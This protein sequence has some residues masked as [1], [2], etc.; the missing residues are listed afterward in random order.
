L[1]ID[2]QP[3]GTGGRKMAIMRLNFYAQ[4][5]G[6]YTNVFVHIPSFNQGF[7]LEK[8]L[9]ELYPANV[10][11]QTMWLLHGGS[12]DDSLFQNCTNVM[13]YAD[14]NKLAVV[15]PCDYNAGYTDFP[16][17]AKYFTYIAE[18]LWDF[19]MANF[20]ISDKREDNFVAGNSMGGGGA[21]KMA[22]TYPER[23]AAAV[24]L[25]GGGVPRPDSEAGRNLALGNMDFWKRM[26]DVGWPMPTLPKDVE[27]ED[28]HDLLLKALAEGKKLPKFFIT[29]GEEDEIVYETAKSAA[30]YMPTLGLDVYSEFLPGYKH[31]W[32]FWD[33]SLRKVIY[34][35]LPLKRTHIIEN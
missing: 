5:L 35:W 4:T 1:P 10:K 7:E 15:I 30:E 25:S 6:M 21:T 22:L 32:D 23:F 26:K 12:D 29:C 8:S 17:S 18:E 34:E 31:E 28:P 2:R 13:R 3:D 9:D 14:E 19:M 11:F 24:L 27:R 20:P 33:L 16:R